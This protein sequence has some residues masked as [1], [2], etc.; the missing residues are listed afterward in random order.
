M[1]TPTPAG[2]AWPVRL[3][4]CAAA[5]F[6]LA[7]AGTNLSYGISKGGDAASSAVWGA[8][9]LAVSI[10]FALSWPAL[11]WAVQN[12]QWMFLPM[13]TAALLLTGAYSMT[14]ALGSASGGRANAS[15]SEQLISEQRTRA[16][17]SYSTAQADLATLN[18]SRPVAEIE[19][20]L[21]ASSARLHGDCA[22]RSVTGRLV[23]PR[24]A[25]LSAELALSRAG[26]GPGR[27]KPPM[28]ATSE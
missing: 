13:A 16:Q 21:A 14:A 26:P 24:N 1:L 15:A 6:T 27:L 8:V 12:R 10:V 18:P 28:V 19:A 23:C 3:A 2:A 5:I 9:S 25:T 7:S 17:A 4:Y 11:I 22:V 20:L